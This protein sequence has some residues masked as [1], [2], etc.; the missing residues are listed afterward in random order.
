MDRRTFVTTAS[1]SAATPSLAGAGSGSGSGATP[2]TLAALRDYRAAFNA[3][4]AAPQGEAKETAFEALR[5]REAAFVTSPTVTREDVALKLEFALDEGLIGREYWGELK[6][7]DAAMF[8][9]MIGALR[10]VA[11]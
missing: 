10:G 8:K 5:A 3:Y 4:D 9:S 7:L 6:G 11:A 1:I 2:A